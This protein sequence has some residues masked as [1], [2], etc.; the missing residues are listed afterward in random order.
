MLTLRKSLVELL[1]NG[2]FSI[3]PVEHG[4]DAIKSWQERSYDCSIININL[5]DTDG[6]DFSQNV[7]GKQLLSSLACFQQ[8]WLIRR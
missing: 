5:R 2:D 3:H 1:E 8:P 4:E 6:P 7:F